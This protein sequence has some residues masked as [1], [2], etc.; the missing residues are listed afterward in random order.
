ME[1][2]MSN[3]FNKDDY[4]KIDPEPHLIGDMEPINHFPGVQMWWRAIENIRRPLMT[5]A[6][7]E[8]F[9]GIE[10][11]E[12]EK[13]ADPN[14]LLQAMDKYGVD[15]ACLLP[16][17]MMDTT[18]YTSRWCTNGEMAR[19][20]DSNPDRFMYQ[21]NISPIKHKG[22]KNTIWELEYWVKEKGAKIFK[23]Y[24]PEDT[25]INDP[26]IWPF[27][28]KAEELGIV[29]DIH[30]GFCWVPPGKS[31]YAL[32]ILLDD[33]ARD[34]PDLRINAFHMGYPYC[35]DLNMIAMG[36]PNVYVCLS[37]LIP[38]ARAAPRKFAKI[39][40]EALRWVGPDKIIWGTDFAGFGAQIRAAV[41]GMRE[42]QIPEDM[43]ESYGYPAITD[44]DRTK[45]FG[46]NLAGLLGIDTSRRRI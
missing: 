19:I 32:P 4:F 39:I 11:W 44:E 14:K 8:S 30:T 37:L 24:P 5:G 46:G 38:W 20:V 6:P 41:I 3:E 33:V 31:K 23:F 13:T 29:L 1:G 2:P 43:Q 36:H 7:P 34:F 25:Y 10:E 27:Y 26:D 12:M 42:F 21:P 18:G 17:S 15:I 9:E 22:V 40:G 16:E 28:E 35:D 45:I